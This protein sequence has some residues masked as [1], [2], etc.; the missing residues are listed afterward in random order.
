MPFRS[1][2]LLVL[3]FPNSPILLFIADCKKAALTQGKK[4]GE[5]KANGREMEGD[6]NSLIG[7]W[8]KFTKRNREKGG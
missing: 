5:R 6:G 7:K 1:V 4:E 8:A 2:F 3:P